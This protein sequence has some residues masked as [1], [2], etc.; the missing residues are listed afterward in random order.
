MASTGRPT[1]LTPQVQTSICERLSEGAT[2]EGAAVLSGV[3]YPAFKSWMSRGSD[4]EEPFATFRAAVTQAREFAKQEAIKNV[5]GGVLQ[6]G[7]RDWKAESWWLERMYP[8]DFAPQASVNVKV[9]KEL[10]GILDKVK[11][12]LSAD[13]YNA[14]LAAIIGEAGSEASGG[15]TEGD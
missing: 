10:E 13:A 6:S 2:Y 15:N 4:G 3:S 12:A 7:M 9:E 8:E 1:S 11:G 5:R 14:A